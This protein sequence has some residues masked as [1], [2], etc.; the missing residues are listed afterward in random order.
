L[1]ET[2]LSDSLS[3]KP[4]DNQRLAELCGQFDE[5]LRLLEKRLHVQIIPHG[6]QFRITG[7]TS[8]SVQHAGKILL[9][10]YDETHNNGHLT[11]SKV[12][13]LLQQHNGHDDDNDEDEEDTE[14][15]TLYNKAGRILAHGKNQL[16]Y[17]KNIFHNDINFA[18]GPAGTGKTF[19]AVAMAIDALEKEKVQRIILTRPAVE[20][21]ERLGYLPGD[22]NQKIDPYLRPLYDALYH[23]LGYEKVNK[24][25][26]KRIIE[27]A[28]L[29]YMRGR[30]LSD[31][32]IILDEGQNT[33]KEQMKMFLTRIGF[34]SR[35]IITGDITQI[36]LPNKNMSGL[37]HALKVL[38]NTT[39]I[40]FNY[41]VAKDAVRHPIV[42]KVIEAYER[43]EAR[44]QDK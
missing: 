37:N 21:G 17:L 29:A 20:A 11:P 15:Y 27:I 32:F 38:K 6:N 31:A 25:V 35:A 40:S 5:H 19:L 33:T 12:H 28:P 18:I 30:T 41:F 16:S 23:M 36:D 10:L 7:E 43:S 1:K 24:L 4:F 34:G 22:L 44:N 42:Q 26:T 2:L 3:F 39:S 9:T 8:R 13:L 14:S